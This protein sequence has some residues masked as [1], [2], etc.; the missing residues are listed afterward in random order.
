MKAS[1][2]EESMARELS[3]SQLFPDNILWFLQEMEYQTINEVDRL[4]GQIEVNADVQ[5]MSSTQHADSA[6]AISGDNF[7]NVNSEELKRLNDLNFNKNTKRSTNTW[8][9]RFESWKRFHCQTLM[10]FP[11][12]LPQS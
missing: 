10:K 5:Q 1:N 12:I 3:A 9:I 7:V 11:F 4:I 8:I 6:S 2:G